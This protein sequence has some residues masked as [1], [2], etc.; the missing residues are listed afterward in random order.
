MFDPKKI[1]E[2]ITK[3]TDKGVIKNAVFVAASGK[4]WVEGNVYGNPNFQDGLYIHTSRVVAV[5]K[6][7]IETLNSFYTCEFDPEGPVLLW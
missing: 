4:F 6:N 1:L 7:R 3:K 5:N 2:E